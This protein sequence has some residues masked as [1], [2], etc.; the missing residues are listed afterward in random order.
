MVVRRAWCGSSVIG[1]VVLLSAV[2]VHVPEMV[3]AQGSG[4]PSVC[5]SSRSL[6]LHSRVVQLLS[7]VCLLSSELRIATTHATHPAGGRSMQH[8]TIE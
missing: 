6:V 2:R 5:A 3:S 7:A 1:A 4:T 8:G